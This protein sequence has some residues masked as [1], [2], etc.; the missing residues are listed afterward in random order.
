MNKDPCM[1]MRPPHIGIVLDEHN[2]GKLGCVEVLSPIPSKVG[3]VL[4]HPS[5]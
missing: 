4:H 2:A 1:G 3:P 5:A